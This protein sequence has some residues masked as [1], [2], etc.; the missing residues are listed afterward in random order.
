MSQYFSKKGIVSYEDAS[1]VDAF[2]RLRI[3]AAQTIFDSKQLYDKS[4]LF[5]DEVISGGAT[6]VYDQSN[7]QTVLTVSAPG[8]SV[9]RQTKQRFNYQPGKSQLIL[10]TG[11]FGTPVAGVTRRVGAFDGENGMFFELNGTTLNLVIRKNSIDTMVPQGS[12]NIDNFDGNGPSD[13][14]FDSE[15]G[16]VFV[17][18]YEWL[19]LGRVRFGFF[20]NGTLYYAHQFVFSNLFPTVYT[21]TPNA[22]LRYQITSTVAIGPPGADMTHIC[23]TVVSE[24]GLNETGYIRA[25]GTN[26]IHLVATSTAIIYPVL[27]MRLKAT[28]LDATIIP[29]TLS[30]ISATNDAFRWLLTFNPTVTGAF[31][32]G[33]LADSALEI[34][35][36]TN[37]NTITAAPGT[38]IAEGYA[39]VDTL[40]ASAD[41]SSAQKLGATVGGVRDEL[42]LAVQ[43]INPAANIHASLNWRELV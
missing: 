25:A 4:P 35:R 9:I 10:M 3:S 20:V 6:S 40:Q 14:I 12:W 18:D 15:Q 43:G 38:I 36:F 27:G 24:G 5:W 7:A 32:Y 42:I 2:E 11:N 8:D 22:P 21:R 19:G 26:N 39:S 33:A 28:H 13:A 16:Q 31:A 34:C 29:T 41:L 37:T 30:M 17:I 23:G 1:T